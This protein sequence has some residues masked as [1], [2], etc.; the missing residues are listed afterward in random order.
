MAFWK[1]ELVGVK[2]PSCNKKLKKVRYESNSTYKVITY[3]VVQVVD[4][5]QV[6]RYFSCWK[7]LSKT[8]K[9][10][11]HYRSLFEE[12]TDYEKNKKVII[13][14]NTTWTGDGFSSSDYEIRANKQPYLR[15]SE[16][17]RFVSDFNTPGAEFL[18]RFNKY[19][20][21]KDFHNCDYRMLLRMLESSPKI[22]TLF[23]A[24]QKELLFFAV[25]KDGG[26]K[27]HRF[28]P[29]IK[30]ALRQKF[31]IKDASIWYDYLEML[32]EFGKDLRNPKFICPPD[33]KVQHDK[34]MNKKRKI[35]EARRR[36]REIEQIAI[37]Q[38]NIELETQKYAEKIV[39]FLGLRFQSENL[40]IV[41]LQ[42]VQEFKEEGDELKH[43]VYTN[44]YYKLKNSLI[45]SAR[46]DGKRTETIEVL[47][48]NFTISQARGFGNKSSNYHDAIIDLVKKNMPKIKAVMKEKKVINNNQEQHTEAA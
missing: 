16:Y 47:L 35:E 29:Q 40:V 18:P 23:K 39:Q 3:S 10:K 41:P 30:I 26:G 5:F 2:C 44:G 21:G 33:L 14:R 20:L 9:P 25:H 48:S 22:E 37:E 46:V 19:G 24:K 13:G 28:W 8:A 38:K 36:Q 6:V 15:S 27:H 45:L 12:W 17:D 42:S 11:Y 31:K 43:C 4:R 7:H 34:W 1:E 32:S